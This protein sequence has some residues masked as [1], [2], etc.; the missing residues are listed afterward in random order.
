MAEARDARA[1]LY[2]LFAVNYFA[3]GLAGLAYESVDYLLKDRLRL[4]SAAAALFV[5]WM[6]LP[7]TLKPLFGLVSDGL[8]WNGRRRVPH[9]IAACGLSS[10][11][12]LALALSRGY[13][14][15]TT[16]AWLTIVNVGTVLADAACEGLMIER[17]REI[18]ST[19]PFQAVKVGML[20][21]SLVVSGLGGGWLAARAD[22]RMV[23]LIAALLP[24]PAAAVALGV[25]DEVVVGGARAAAARGFSALRQAASRPGFWLISG[26]VFLWSFS[27]FL[28]IAE[29]YYQTRALK[30]SP[31]FIGAL[32]TASGAAGALAASAF[33]RASADRSLSPRLAR[34]SIPASAVLSAL[35]LFYVGPRSAMALA[36]IFGAVGV[37]FR[38]AWID[39]CARA[40]PPGAEAATFA[41][42]MAVF[43]L[44]AAASNMAG[45]ALY[46]RLAAA[47]GD[48]F[49][50]AALGL[51]GGACSL[52]AWPL[53]RRAAV[54]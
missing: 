53:A 14:Y 40:C 20:Y 3:Q 6:T 23:F 49:A 47:R 38:L 13:D 46:D 39:L 11:A 19:G 17:G 42:F 10:A 50:M 29:F 1:R 15:K 2:A 36:V 52:A 31:L 9:L 16:L 21:V 44:A 8:P 43:N 45:G 51:A 32:T 25:D 34:L 33:A 37:A 48:Y 7:L 54:L 30:L 22:Y 5:T 12:W 35:Y 18:E 26:S 28:G 24:L 4:G 27:P 41:A